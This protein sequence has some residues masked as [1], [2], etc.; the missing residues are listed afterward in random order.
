MLKDKLIVF[1]LL[2]YSKWTRSDKLCN[3]HLIAVQQ[4]IGHETQRQQMMERQQKNIEASEARAKELRRKKAQ[5]DALW[6]A[7]QRD[8]ELQKV[9][10]QLCKLH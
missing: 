9:R 8:R 4:M 2:I 1:C 10:N 6:R 3:V 5:Q 7:Q